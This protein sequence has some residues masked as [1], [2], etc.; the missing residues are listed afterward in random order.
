MS[1]V[2]YH[3]N[4]LVSETT[5]VEFTMSGNIVLPIGDTAER[6]TELVGSIRFNSELG[7]VEARDVNGWTPIGNF[8]LSENGDTSVR[9][10]ETTGSGDGIITF[11]V[12]SSPVG[13]M[14][15]NGLTIDGTT[16]S[17]LFVG[18]INGGTY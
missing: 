1:A 17:T 10:E 7:Y 3:L 18:E 4:K 8:L 12:Q 9:V 15:I 14:D 6:A 5:N 16:T 2:V 13:Y 11:T